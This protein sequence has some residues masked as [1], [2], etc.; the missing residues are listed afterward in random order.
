[1]SNN[2]IWWTLP[3]GLVLGGLIGLV[4]GI[5]LEDTNLWMIMGAGG[6]LVLGL[7]VGAALQRR[8]THRTT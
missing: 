4:V 6:G 1:M 5:V 2:S 3:L 8:E 7:A